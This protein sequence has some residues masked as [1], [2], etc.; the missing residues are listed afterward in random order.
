[1]FAAALAWPMAA[2][3]VF[4]CSQGAPTEGWVL[5]AREWGLLWK[6]MWLSG[7]GVVG[8]LMLGCPVGLCLAGARGRGVWVVAAALVLLTPPMV[9][10]F[11]WGALWPGWLGDEARCV[12]VWSLWG[13]PVAAQFVG[14]RWSR[15]GRRAY[16]SALLEARAWTA[17]WRVGFAAVRGSVAASALV[18]FVLFFGDYG[19]PHA[20]GLMVH[21]TELLLR[22]SSSPRVMDTVWPAAPGVA[23]IGGLLW[24]VFR[25]MGLRDGSGW[26]GRSAD[27]G[28]GVGMVGAGVVLASL[29][30]VAVLTACYGSMEALA[31][32]WWTYGRDLAWSVGVAGMA[33]VLGVVMGLAVAA[34]GRGWAGVAIGA[35]VV[36]GAIPGA[37]VGVAL[38][39]AYNHAATGWV[40]DHFGIVVLCHVA[41]FGWIGMIAGWVAVR[42]GGDALVGQ[43]MVDGMGRVAARRW[44]AVCVHWPVLAAGGAMIAALALGELPASTVVRVPTFAPVAHLMVEKFHRFEHGMLFALSALTVLSAGAAGMAA[45]AAR[46]ASGR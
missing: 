45:L 33:G 30:P 23:L 44:L 3:G 40:Y 43:A 29:A 5:S 42:G 46:R 24:V 8:S 36:F 26:E 25:L 28:W 13:W 35:G 38:A 27:A 9:Y 1:M 17:F 4:G 41:R 6:S 11:G 18:L 21:A 15:S 7:A 16:E 39:A 2:L 14:A 34:E 19:V 32:T 12:A 31:E 37:V 22:A 20:C 10:A